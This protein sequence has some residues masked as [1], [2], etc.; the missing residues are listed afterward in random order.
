MHSIRVSALLTFGICVAYGVSTASLWASDLKVEIVQGVCKN[1]GQHS[2]GEDAPLQGVVA[3][4]S[5]TARGSLDTGTNGKTAI[6]LPSNVK[7]GMTE[8][9]VVLRGD[10]LLD[11]NWPPAGNLVIPDLN[12]STFSRLVV[13]SKG[14]T[15]ALCSQEFQKQLSYDALASSPFQSATSPVEGSV[16]L[17]QEEL[18]ELSKQFEKPS[19]DRYPLGLLALKISDWQLAADSFASS[20]KYRINKH[21]DKQPSQQLV[22]DAAY[23]LGYS[24]YQAQEFAA[25]AQAF[26]QSDKYEKDMPLTLASYAISLEQ[27]RGDFDA[28]HQAYTRALEGARAEGQPNPLFR[29]RLLHSFGGYLN[30]QRKYDEA[31]Q[32]LKEAVALLGQLPDQQTEEAEGYLR[33]AVELLHDAAPEKLAIAQYRLAAQLTDYYDKSH[34]AEAE[35]LFRSSCHALRD[36]ADSLDHAACQ[37]DYAE[38]LRYKGD[39]PGAKLVLDGLIDRDK[40]DAIATK[41]DGQRI[42]QKVGILLQECDKQKP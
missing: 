23:L 21:Q 37:A 10:E 13:Q 24:Y 15:S 20:L 1:L 9:I 35:E 7:A 6:P 32:R 12:T 17:T 5:G 38:L 2:E 28:V 30:N 36:E 18:S 39:C 29:A 42:A 31:E 27:A 22:A 4:V 3:K 8:T 11:V 33:S 40:L 14:E 19:V 16:S 34:Y 41:P 25:A 26:G